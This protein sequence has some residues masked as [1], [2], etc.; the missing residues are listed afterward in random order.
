MPSLEAIM[1][2]LWGLSL[3]TWVLLRPVWP[4]Q[5]LIDLSQDQFNLFIL[6]KDI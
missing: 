3:M 1:V 6:Q 2:S 5:V 4:G